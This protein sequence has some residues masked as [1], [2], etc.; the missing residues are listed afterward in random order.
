[1]ANLKDL[2]SF[3]QAPWNLVMAILVINISV[4]SFGFDQS[5]F[6]TIQA[7]NAYERQFGAYNP[8]SETWGFSAVHLSFLNSF[9]LPAKWLGAVMDLLFAEKLGRRPTYIAMQFIVIIGIAVSYTAKTFRQ[10]LAGRIIVQCFV[11]WIT[12]LLQCFSL[13]SVRRFFEVESW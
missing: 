1:M 11:G 4:F 6:S 7:M 13:R 3:G 10:A 9:S 5:V 8:K 12:S 2:R